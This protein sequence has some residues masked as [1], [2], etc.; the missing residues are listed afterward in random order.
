MRGLKKPRHFALY[1]PQSGLFPEF[2]LYGALLIPEETNQL[3]FII[4]WFLGYRALESGSEGHVQGAQGGRRR[5]QARVFLT[6]ALLSSLP[7]ISELP[8]GRCLWWTHPECWHFVI[9]V[10]LFISAAPGRKAFRPWNLQG[11][12]EHRPGAVRRNV[13]PALLRGDCDFYVRIWSRQPGTRWE[14]FGLGLVLACSLLKWGVAADN[15]WKSTQREWRALFVALAV[16]VLGDRPGPHLR[17]RLR[18][19][20]SGWYCRPLPDSGFFFK[21]GP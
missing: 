17:L 18:A 9:F 15:G 7:T 10:P 16:P 1:H 5:D 3:P 11:D 20:L 4:F 19:G 12:R 21:V 14:L 2:Y 8:K 13:I 6:L